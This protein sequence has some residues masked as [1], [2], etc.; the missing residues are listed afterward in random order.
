MFGEDTF[1]DSLHK[2]AAELGIAERI[3]FRGFVD[4]IHSELATFDVLVHSSVIPEP[5]GNV[6]VE[7]MA[8]GLPVIAPDSGGPAEVITGGLDGILYPMGDA[9][10]LAECLCMVDGDPEMRSRIGLRAR[11]TASGFSLESV[12][13]QLLNVY[14]KVAGL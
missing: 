12:A 7:G 10:S 1:A 8:A 13:P 11:Q 9:A 14:K 5:F 6:V 3:T 4:D 2:L